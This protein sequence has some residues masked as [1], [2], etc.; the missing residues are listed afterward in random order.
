MSEMAAI[1]LADHY[2]SATTLQ[3][4]ICEFCRNSHSISAVPSAI[5][6]KVKNCTT[7]SMTA[8]YEWSP[9]VRLQRRLRTMVRLC[10]G[11]GTI[12]V[13][14]DAEKESL[15]EKGMPNGMV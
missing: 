1:L 12:A 13:R 3:R 6:E 8:A 11:A 4:F 5:Y 14:P 7:A 2:N 10:V 9:A 15:N